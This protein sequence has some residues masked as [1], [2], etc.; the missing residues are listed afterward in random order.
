[1]PDNEGTLRDILQGF[2][3][4]QA[5]LGLTPGS[6]QA[7]GIQP[8]NTPPV[9]HPGEVSQEASIRLQQSTQQTAQTI[10]QIQNLQQ[11]NVMAFMP[12]GG[13]GGG[14]AAG[15]QFARQFQQ[16]MGQIEAG[17]QD[18]FQAQ[19]MA[20]Q[21]GQ[22]GFMTLPSPTFMTPPS[23]GVFRPGFQQPP[24]I[25][26]AR[27]PPMI[28]TPFTPQLPRP[29]F[30]TPAQMEQ[31][32]TQMESNEMFAGTM[33]AIPTAARVAMGGGGVALGMKMGGRFGTA[34]RIAGGIAGG[35][36]GFGP[37]GGLAERGAEAA[38]QPAIERRAFGL[39]MQNIS[40][41]FVV[42]GPELAEGGRGLN[43][44]AG[45]Q[46]ANQ[47]RRA[48]DK[49]ETAGFNMRDMMGIT[50]AAGDMGMMDMAQNSEQIVAQAKNIARGLS[51][52]MR[53]ANEP[54]VR[55]AMQQM[56]QMR[57][58]GLTV[59]E[60][61]ASMQNA[62]QFAR[63]AGTSVASLSQTA[64]MPGAMTFQQMGMTAGLGY[65][66]GMGAGG[67]ARQAVASGAFTPGQ[68]AMA[69]G[70]R[71]VQQQMTEAAGATLG[72]NFPMMAMLSRNEQGQL[73]IDREKARRIASGEV[74][75]TE[76]AGMAQQNVE[77]LGGAKVITE[78]STRL[79]ELRDQLGRTLGPQGSLLYTLQQGMAMQ[80]ELGG[81]SVM[82]IGGALRALGLNPQQARTMEVMAQS[83]QFWKNMQQQMQSQVDDARR[84]E[85][86]RRE[87]M[88]E[89]STLTAQMRRGLRP[90][91][92]AFE[93]V[94]E[95]VTGAYEGI[96]QW[97]SDRGRRS[98]A[99]ERG[100]GFVR[101][102]EDL[103]VADQ[104]QQRE[105]DRFVETGGFM[106]AAERY[107]AEAQRGTRA[108]GGP[109]N[110]YRGV[111]GGRFS[112]LLAAS[113]A[114]MAVAS[115]FG[116]AE[117]S[118]VVQA[119]RTIG[120][121]RGAFASYFPTLAAMTGDEED[122]RRAE[123]IAETGQVMA[124]G[125]QMSKETALR[126]GRESDKAYTEYVRKFG[127]KGADANAPASMERK[128]SDAIINK[129]KD[130]SSWLGD[131]G[132]TAEDAKKAAIE[133]AVQSGADRAAVTKYVNQQWSKGL[134]QTVMRRVQRQ[135]PESAKGALAKTLE[136]EGFRGAM[137]AADLEKVVE[138]LEDIEEKTKTQLGF[139]D[140]LDSTEKSY[141]EVTKLLTTTS[142]DEMMYMQALAMKDQ[143]F[144]KEADAMMR[145]LESR[146][147]K[148]QM[149]KLEEKVGTRVKDMDE[150]TRDM[151]SQS[152]K[153]V[154]A[155]GDPKEQQARLEKFVEKI[156][157]TRTGQQVAAGAARLK[158]LGVTALKKGAFTEDQVRSSMQNIMMS[159]EQM[160]ALSKASPEAAAAV[161]EFKEA[162]D[163]PD[164][165]KRA[166]GKFQRAVQRR[167]A[168]ERKE[169]VFGGKGVGGA[170]EAG[171]QKQIG[172]I[173]KM[174]QQLT[175]DPQKDFARTVPLFAKAAAKLNKAAEQFENGMA[176][177]KQMSMRLKG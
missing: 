66:V 58:M 159:E 44:R 55:R 86:T 130:K 82:G 85:A 80:K 7:Q 89:T 114:A 73:T 124:Q 24:P 144:D 87:R 170:R 103:A 27:T 171:L 167:G 177:Q 157:F 2:N 68:L 174:A 14:S 136:A 99:A 72:V 101:Y 133:G 38:L 123:S 122:V 117:T 36:L 149:R 142:T 71:G 175:G 37:G 76:Q 146:L 112:P 121:M 45:I 74:S 34:G 63:M 150:D 46:T 18:P 152:G 51:A 40:R 67:M 59:P 102:S 32:Q 31:A 81:P 8:L 164:K 56:A 78:L 145:G 33:A 154:L 138:N 107:G 166:M 54:D 100:A 162:G 62:Q 172:Q 155:A 52:F 57:S 43:M 5:R 148:D 108:G 42:S 128:M 95:M 120:G 21:M 147:D 19:Q 106:R 158:E 6:A 94:G 9:K 97:W 93:R 47:M 4:M 151:L 1:M 28:Q 22:P 165:Q 75:L 105:M 26:M 70:M 156:K 50:S 160:E 69:G 11:P 110:I 125:A 92:R 143:G 140:G 168:A 127:E 153:A 129:L 169:A 126:L 25:A 77:Q 29:M 48:V 118:P 96:S 90:V 115:I 65:N 15:G 30:Q 131:K 135:A 134:G 176:M 3:S 163:D 141:K 10:Q 98:R 88:R 91:G 173:E 41:N 60:T 137:A 12:P 111:M 84:E 64:G 20:Q 13:L 35:L 49:G 17:Y 61:T 161:E 23:M 79:N 132:L 16:R 53:L 109:G 39:Q 116:D 83:P 139:Y 104:R 113:P 119:Q